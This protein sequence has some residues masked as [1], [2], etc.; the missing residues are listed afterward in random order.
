MQ[1]AGDSPFGISD[2]VGNVSEWVADYY[3]ADYYTASAGEDNPQGPE[4]G[5]ER[6]IKGSAFTV[7]P[8][9]PAQRISKR[10]FATPGTALRIYGVRCAR[11]R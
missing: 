1:A 3:D 4:S 9:F 5:S 7:P 11:D 6:V 2:M 8:D 10:N